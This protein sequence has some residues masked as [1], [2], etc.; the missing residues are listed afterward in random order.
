[1]TPQ[2]N[3]PDYFCEDSPEFLAVLCDMSRDVENLAL[4]VPADGMFLGYR[5]RLFA[6]AR[7]LA[8]IEGGLRA[9]IASQPRERADGRSGAG[10]AEGNGGTPMSVRRANAPRVC[11]RRGG[12]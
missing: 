6:V 4:S 12:P 7:E 3:R 8:A 1:M 9:A 5:E 11:P 10:D 2:F